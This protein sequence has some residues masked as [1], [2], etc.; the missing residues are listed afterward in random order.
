MNL[1]NINPP[2]HIDVHVGRMSI[3]SLKMA[4]A[5]SSKVIH[6]KKCSKAFFEVDHKVLTF[7]VS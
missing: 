3:H 5:Q 6:G 1:R 2:H 7:E 4:N